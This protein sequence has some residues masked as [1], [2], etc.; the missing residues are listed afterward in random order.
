[1]ICG[2]HGVVPFDLLAMALRVG[3]E[4]VHSITARRRRAQCDDGGTRACCLGRSDSLLRLLLR[5][6]D[7]LQRR[8]P[9][10]VDRIGDR[11]NSRQRRPDHVVAVLGLPLA[12]QR[13]ALE[14]GS[15]HV[16]RDVAVSVIEYVEKKC[17]SR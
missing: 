3:E 13:A 17:Q 4:R 15:R 1:M 6:H 7:P 9:R 12:R 2:E 14:D 5:A 11:N 8:V 16:G 10:R